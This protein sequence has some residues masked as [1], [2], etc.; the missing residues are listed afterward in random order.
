VLNMKY[1]IKILILISKLVAL[2]YVQYI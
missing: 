2:T 1:K